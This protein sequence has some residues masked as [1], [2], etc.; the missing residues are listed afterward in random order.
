[1]SRP[2]SAIAPFFASAI[3][4]RLT[5]HI[6]AAALLAG[7][8][9]RAAEKTPPTSPPPSAPPA[10]PAAPPAKPAP[11]PA[12]PAKPDFAKEVGPLIKKYCFD[13]HTGDEPEGDFSLYFETERDLTRRASSEREHF[14]KMA[15]FLR[16]YEM[17]P[18]KKPQP[19]NTEREKILEWIYLAMLEPTEPKGDPTSLWR[20]RKV[21]V[22]SRPAHPAIAWRP[23]WRSEGR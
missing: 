4:N 19:T 23:A 15:D 22:T 17:P 14:E 12:A 11:A 6:L 3:R 16:E 20:S 13:C 18:R 2:L 8:W 9:S 7:A 21:P 5:R 1:M 10:P